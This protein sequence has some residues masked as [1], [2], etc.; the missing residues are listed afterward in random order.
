MAKVQSPMSL[1]TYFDILISQS[2][3]KIMC[4]KSYFSVNWIY[5]I[6]PY[7]VKINDILYSLSGTQDL[8]EIKLGVEG[9]TSQKNNLLF[10]AAYIKGSYDIKYIKKV[11]GRNIILE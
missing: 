3:T 8:V 11:W 5:N 4:Y 7:A 6:E 10:N 1:K 9:K 2:N